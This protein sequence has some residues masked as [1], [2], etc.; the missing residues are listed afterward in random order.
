M[1]ASLRTRLLIGVVSAVL[2]LLSLFSIGIYTAIRDALLG[3][4]DVSLVS[5]AQVLAASL[6]VDA[7][8]IELELEVQQMPEFQDRERPTHYQ[9]WRMDGTVVAKSPLLEN[10]DL[11]RLEGS[12]I[13]PAFKEIKGKG[14]RVER[15][16]GFS[17]L[18]RLSDSNDKPPETE[19]LMLAVARDSTEILSQLSFLRWVLL[20]ASASVTVL[21]V[22]VAFM[23]VHQ[24]LRPLNAIAAEIAAIKEDELS[25]RVGA[26][27]AP[28]E[29]LPIKDRLNELLS[30]LEAAFKRERRFTADVA[31]ELRTPIAGMRS[32]IEVTAARD[33]DKDEY[34]KVLSDC[35]VIVENMQTMVNDLLML[36][37]LDA[38]QISFQ[39]EQI[40]LGELMSSCWRP[41]C[42]KA[43]QRQILFE[44]QI[45]PEITCQSDPKYLSM[46]F[47]NLL[48][49]A[50]EYADDGGQIWT[51]ACRL[52]DSVEVA[53]SNT[54][55]H[56]T[57]EQVSQ[58]FDRFWRGDS[59]RSETGT[60][61]GLGL[62]LVQRLAKALG[63]QATAELQPGGILTIR[64]KLP[65]KPC[66]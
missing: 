7:N 41:V 31:H 54:G 66:V 3:Q 19:S 11:P 58:V 44:N 5:M 27:A 20:V 24:G 51:T 52:G 18:P 60:H 10:S 32:M 1:K 64:L 53:V 16:V 50:V 57:G 21:S 28:R 61:C 55:C 49:N 46:I 34:E 56:L 2:L 17:F 12:V 29:L 26:A 40:R 42:D 48:G 38:Q 36:A 8:E 22:L 47:S 4:F 9:V 35:H 14:G 65:A 25:T 62:A 13:K 43:L 6:E 23:V 30:R 37:R 33:R 45:G 39:T 63:G 15:V 59:A